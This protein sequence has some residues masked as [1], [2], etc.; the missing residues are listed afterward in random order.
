MMAEKLFVAHISRGEEREP[1]R[2]KYDK[3]LDEHTIRRLSSLYS[4]R[5][6]PPVENCG[7]VDIYFFKVK[8]ERRDS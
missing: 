2:L 5:F 6:M 8:R 4:A 7:M 3:P 1:T